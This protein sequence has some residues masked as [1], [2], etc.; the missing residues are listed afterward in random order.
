MSIWIFLPLLVVIFLLDVFKSCQGIV[1]Q[2]QE[3]PTWNLKL[4]FIYSGQWET[5]ER[6][7]SRL[8]GGKSYKKENLHMRV[9]LGGHKTKIS[10]PTFQNLHIEALTG[11]SHTYHP[12]NFNN[13]LIFQECILEKGFLYRNNGQTVYSEDRGEGEEPL[14][15]Q[16]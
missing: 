2:T 1:L 14:I 4:T 15:A 9:V 7:H 16:V 12:D 10:V 13:T 3:S 8:L 5:K 11:F 6:D